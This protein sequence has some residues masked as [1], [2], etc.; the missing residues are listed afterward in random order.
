MVS[1]VRHRPVVDGHE[2]QLSGGTKSLHILVVQRNTWGIHVRFR[3]ECPVRRNEFTELPRFQ[4]R[5]APTIPIAKCRCN[6]VWEHFGQ[7]E[8][9]PRQPNDGRVVFDA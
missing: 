3:K 2:R 7:R 9:C 8:F 5:V 6:F 1:S 4:L